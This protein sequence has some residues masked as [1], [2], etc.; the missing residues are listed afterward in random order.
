MLRTYFHH[1]TRFCLIKNAVAT[2]SP[3]IKQVQLS[4]Y[5]FIIN[6]PFPVAK[7]AMTM[8]NF[9]F[10]RL[11]H[12]GHLRS[13]TPT[14]TAIAEAHAISC[15]PGPE[16]LQDSDMQYPASV[17]AR[18][19]DHGM[20]QKMRLY[21]EGLLSQP[22]EKSLETIAALAQIPVE[23]TRS[24]SGAGLFEEGP[25]GALKAPATIIHGR[26]DFAFE[27]RLVLNGLGDYLTR[28]SQVLVLEK[29]GHWM[30]TEEFAVKVI[31]DVA[32]WALNG[33]KTSLREKLAGVKDVTILVDKK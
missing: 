5:I 7:W 30:P 9:W 12:R 16:Q 10:L 18:V 8:G 21:R 23:P 13:K 25:P 22:W 27:R 33:E 1:P 32:E 14:A 28:K 2:L 31:A 4:F 24:G 11:C 15:G 29:S 19:P 6:L 3:V 20:S 17:Q 26:H